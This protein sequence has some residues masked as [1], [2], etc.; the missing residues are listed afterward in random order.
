M[1]IAIVTAGMTGKGKT[2][3]VKELIA[4]SGMPEFIFDIHK[5]YQMN[6]SFYGSFKDFAE[7]ASKLKNHVIVFEEAS[8]FFKR[9][10][11][12]NE[13]VDAMLVNKRHMGDKGCMLIFNFHSLRKVPLDILDLINFIV[14]LKTNDVPKNVM[15]RFGDY[16]GIFEAFEKVNASKNE[17]EKIT[18]KLN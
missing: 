14:I 8:I 9:S 4:K 3:L 7:K 1:A 5:E 11:G 10:R 15:Q 13:Y 18:L 17:H 16:A 6:G 2:T 12:I